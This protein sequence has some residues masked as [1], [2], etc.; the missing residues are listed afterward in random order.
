MK[1]KKIVSLLL[2]LLMVLSAVP[3]LALTAG[4]E[5]LKTHNWYLEDFE[6]LTTGMTAQEI[7]TTLGWTDWDLT[8]ATLSVVEVDGD[9]KIKILPV[10]GSGGKTTFAT[11]A[12]NV[13]LDSKVYLDYELT[14]QTEGTLGWS[15]S[16]CTYQNYNV[17]TT[18]QL[19]M[20]LSFLQNGSD[21]RDNIIVQGLAITGAQVKNICIDG[22]WQKDNTNNNCRNYNNW[23]TWYTTR[24]S[25]PYG[26]LAVNTKNAV[27]K[28]VASANNMLSPGLNN[29]TTT[30]CL[31]F[32]YRMV[33][34]PDG[35]GKSFLSY[36]SAN[37]TGSKNTT[38][39]ATTAYPYNDTYN[40]DEF[41]ANGVNRILAD[42]TF[43]GKC[44]ATL[45]YESGICYLLD[46]VHV[47]S[48][49][50]LDITVNGEA[51]YMMS[52]TVQAA[53]FAPAGK[54]TFFADVT[55]SGITTRYG[56]NES[57]TLADGMVIKTPYTVDIT[58]Q[59][60][61]AVRIQTDDA[62]KN[63]LRWLTNISK[64]D[65][66]ALVA[67]MS[68]QNDTIT[69]LKVGTAISKTVESNTVTGYANV[70]DLTSAPA[71]NMTYNWYNGSEGVIAGSIVNIQDVTTEFTG[72]GYVSITVDGKTY[73]V[74]SDTDAQDTTR[75]AK[76]VAGMAL[77]DYKAEEGTAGYT[78]KVTSGIYVTAYENGEFTTVEATEAV[79]VWSC[80]T[81]EQL[82]VL[83]GFFAQ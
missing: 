30:T 34:D 67:G 72:V 31:P 2:S 8:V 17:N 66:D 36:V 5:D 54:Q 61:A 39:A 80:Y 68:A 50:E 33:I 45:E 64:A 74:Y 44:A 16:G 70:I 51:R 12:G 52:G 82:T 71:G 38:F 56:A 26:A 22:V 1:T 65:V 21:A 81:D 59:K 77:K 46:D 27:Y 9:K 19:S 69:A 79:P 13:G 62:T 18:S 29:G 23:N 37:G 25:A 83:R 73:T 58:T 42:E 28:D 49:Y 10:D 48:E 35:G 32:I 53:D 4:A 41:W 15:S 20:G 24:M 6:D 11:L 14:P 3:M 76:Y 47:W 43:T 7:K 78:Y 57:T 55:L 40:G 63:G 60:G 75:S